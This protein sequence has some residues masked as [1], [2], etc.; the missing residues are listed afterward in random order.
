MCIRQ[1]FTAPNISHV[2]YR[3]IITGGGKE[4][5]ELEVSEK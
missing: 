1:Y 5:H 2:R 4:C 3:C